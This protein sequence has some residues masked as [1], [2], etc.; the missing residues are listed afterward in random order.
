M[1]G[2]IRLFDLDDIADGDGAPLFDIR[3]SKDYQ[4]KGFGKQ[5]VEWLTTYLFESYPKLNRIEATTRA[6]N[7]SM[8]KVLKNCF[9]L[10]EGHYRASWPSQDG[11]LI[12]TARYAILRNDWIKKSSTPLEWN[13]F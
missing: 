5:A 10:K 8:R 2:I 3:I 6:D 9:F 4:G 1:I 12:D 7:F 11:R 13:D